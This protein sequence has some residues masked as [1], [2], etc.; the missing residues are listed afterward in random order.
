MIDLNKARAARR[1]AEGEAPQVQLGE[2]VFELPV[3]LPFE[4]VEYVTRMAKFTEDSDPQEV[5]A[6]TEGFVKALFG[7]VDYALFLG[8]R[9]TTADIQALLMGVLEEYGLSSG[10][11]P[12]SESS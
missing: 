6:V 12:A 10:E 8:E 11:S 2:K 9:P 7:T 1:E 5:N 3:E 4:C